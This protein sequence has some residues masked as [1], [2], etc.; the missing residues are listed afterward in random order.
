MARN[1]HT[2]LSRR[3]RQIMDIIYRLGQ[4]TAQEV[5]DN[6]ED[7]PSYSAVRAHLRVLVEKKHI[8][9]KYDGPR[10]LYLPTV[11]RDKARRSVEAMC[12]KLLANTVIEN[13]TI[14]LD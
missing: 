12:E 6:L 2:E 10:Y 1:P 7:P 14:D 9:H 8:R 4:A 3:E 5:L 13:Y 11:S